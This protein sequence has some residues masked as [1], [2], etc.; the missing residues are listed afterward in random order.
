MAFSSASCAW[1]ST[2][3]SVLLMLISPQKSWRAKSLEFHVFHWYRVLIWNY[4]R[5]RP[6]T[7][8]HKSK[9]AWLHRDFHSFRRLADNLGN[10]VVVLPELVL[11]PISMVVNCLLELCLRF[12]RL[13][14][15]LSDR[16]SSIECPQIPISLSRKGWTGSNCTPSSLLIVLWTLKKSFSP[17]SPSYLG[18]LLWLVVPSIRDVYKCDS[19]R[20]HL[21]MPLRMT[22]LVPFNFKLLSRTKVFSHRW[23]WWCPKLVPISLD[24]YAH[25][26]PTC[27]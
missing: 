19:W 8:G 16:V 27:S 18:V 3:R 14:R 22:S 20:R 1:K 12:A 2:S 23:N 15:L 17:L 6:L 5:T 21:R 7:E 13:P 26:Q 11:Q 25:L 10:S 4:I 24:I 9:D